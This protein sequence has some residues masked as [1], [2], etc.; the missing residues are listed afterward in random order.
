MDFKFLYHRIT[1]I[2]LNPVKAWDAIYF[3]DRPIKYVRGSFFLPLIIL[4]SISAF[5]GSFL[6]AHSGYSDQYSIMIGVKYFLLM[7]ITG[8]TT[9]YVF[10]EIIRYLGNEGNFT[11]AFKIIIYSLAPFLLCQIISR[12]F[13]SFIFVNVLSLYGLYLCWIGIETMLDPPENRKI[14]LLISAIV[15]FL[16]IFFVVNRLLTMIVDKLYFALFAQ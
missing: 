15:T 14:L 6:F 1:N 8:Y 12:L 7:L 13:E 4:V 16:V 11:C 10:N 5:L 2:I 9:S 3:E